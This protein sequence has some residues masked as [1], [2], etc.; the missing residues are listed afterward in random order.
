[1]T[2]YA[3]KTLR[4]KHALDPRFPLLTKPFSIRVFLRTVRKVIDGG[5]L[6]HQDQRRVSQ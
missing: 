2:G 1:M 6:A 3:E 4:R 5:Q